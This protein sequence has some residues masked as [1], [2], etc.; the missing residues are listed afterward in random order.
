[1]HYVTPDGMVSLAILSDYKRMEGRTDQVFLSEDN[2]VSILLEVID[3]EEAPISLRTLHRLTLENITA[4]LSAARTAE[5]R[6]F[7]TRGGNEAFDTRMKDEHYEYGI[8]TAASQS[9]FATVILA[10]ERTND[11]ALQTQLEDL[12]SATGLSLFVN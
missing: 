5:P 7:I 11:D 12:I 4:E 3:T 8:V 10:A 9:R 1:M 6:F 2:R